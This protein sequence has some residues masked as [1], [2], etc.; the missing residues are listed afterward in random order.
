MSRYAASSSAPQP[1]ILL[2]LAAESKRDRKRRETVNKV[3]MLHNESWASR[4]EKFAQLYKEYHHEN[5]TVNTQPPTSGKYLVRLYPHTI[6]RDALLQA[7]DVEFD[8]KSSQARRMYESERETIEGQ[9]WD[10]RDQVRQRLLGAIEDRR[11]KLREEKEGG[12]VITETL[13][14]AAAR[15]RPFRRLPP[16]RASDSSHPLRTSAAHQLSPP[17][18]VRPTDLLH[19][20]LLAPALAHLNT[21]DILVP[22]GSSLAV[23][24][25]PPGGTY[26]APGKRGPRGKGDEK[27]VGAAPGTGAALALASGQTTAEPGKRSRGAGAGAHNGGWVLGKALSDL[28]KMESASQLE[29]DADWARIQGPQGRGRR[30]RGD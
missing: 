2:P 18:D 17:D 6:E 11:R 25:P 14:D 12:D 26:L 13:L 8:Y 9:Y 19:H 5:K 20:H 7:A 21:D 16:R 15:A 27:D 23:L 22:S 3:E 29:I 4:D 24:P 28:R 10:A 1:N 30:A